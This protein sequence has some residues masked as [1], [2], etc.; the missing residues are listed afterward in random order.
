M[1]LPCPP[2][3]FDFTY[4][5]YG[6]GTQSTALIVLAG[7]GHPDVP[8]PDVAVFADTGD[9]PAW[10]YETL[11]RMT[12]WAGERGIRVDRVAKDHS[13]SES[14]ELG[15]REGKRFVS[16]PLYTLDPESEREG[17]L[18]RQ[19]TREFKI[20]VIEKHVRK[21]MG[22]EPRQV[23][24]GKVDAMAML[25]ISI[26][27]ATRMRPNRTSWITNWWPLVALGL[28]RQDCERVIEDAGLPQP[29]K[30][31]CVYC[32]YHSDAFWL[33]LKEN[34]PD[35]WDEAVA[36]DET[37]RDMAMAGQEQPGYVHR[38]CRPLA[39]LSASDLQGDDPDQRDLFGGAYTNECAGVCGV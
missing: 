33:D 30:S 18:R 39:E 37:I 14:V 1:R 22:F 32:P 36:F 31:S 13:L 35:E 15:K 24:K 21:L 27:E 23:M 3:D 26:D 38:S 6:A 12:E 8:R 5:S 28:S 34:H 17:M 16:V 25:G 9:E 20:E 19:C 4:L 29:G 10:V 7:E 2:A 11:E